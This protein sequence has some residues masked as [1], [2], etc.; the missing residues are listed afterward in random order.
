MPTNVE[1]IKAELPPRWDAE[2]FLNGDD[3]VVI[4]QPNDLGGG[5][6]TLDLKNR[7]FC[8]GQAIPRGIPVPGQYYGT[9]WKKI[10]ARDA[11]KQLEAV[12]A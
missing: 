10:M 11:V 9:G 8:M 4:C 12:M 7:V 6:A 5:F 1:I 2:R 3:V